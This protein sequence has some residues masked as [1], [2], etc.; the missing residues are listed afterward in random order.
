MSAATEAERPPMA[1]PTVTVVLLRLLLLLKVADLGVVWF[2][3]EEATGNDGNGVSRN[4]AAEN[5]RLRL[6]LPPPLFIAQSL[7][8]LLLPSVFLCLKISNFLGA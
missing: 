5:L 3:G 1:A 6:P 8:Y 4:F 2:S 7:G